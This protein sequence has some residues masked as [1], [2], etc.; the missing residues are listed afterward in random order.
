M[1][2][3]V[4]SYIVI[5]AAGAAA[6]FVWRLLGVVYAARLDA[7]DGVLDWVR[8]VATA[9]IAA[10]V[11]RIVL[12]P[13]GALADT[14]LASRLL[15]LVAAVAAF[16][17]GGRTIFAGVGGAVAAFLIAEGLVRGWAG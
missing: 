11:M 14:A 4:N 5:A 3:G 9:L 17:F 16:R 2:E 12:V 8:A 15:A 1:T 6:T 13:P 7:A 10:L